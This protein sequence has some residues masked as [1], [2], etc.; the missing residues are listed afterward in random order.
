MTLANVNIYTIL[1]SKFFSIPLVNPNLVVGNSYNV[2]LLN[3]GAAGALSSGV[4]FL[5]L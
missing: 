2:G 4:V 1:S 5:E 3:K